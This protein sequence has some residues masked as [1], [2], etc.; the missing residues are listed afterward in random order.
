MKIADYIKSNLPYW[1]NSINNI[2]IKINI[3]GK[4]S[5][6]LGYVRYE[7]KMKKFNKEEALLNLV[8]YA[9]KHVPY[10]KK[11][12]GDLEILSISDFEKKIDF[13]DKD[14]VMN[15]WNDFI[16]DEINWDKVTT[17]TTGGTSG[18]PL[19]LVMPQNRY[20]HS[21]YFWHQQLKNFGWNYD[22][23]GVI[24]NHELPSNRVFLIN[25]IMKQFIF[26]GFNTSEE[27]FIKIWRVLNEKK[28]K[29]LHAYPSSAYA[30]LKTC[31]RYKL[32]TSFLR[33]VFL[34]SEVITDFQYQFI[35]H[36]LNIPVLGSYGHSEKLCMAGTTINNFNYVIEENYGYT[37][38]V[39]N[40]KLVS[41]KGIEGEIVGTTYNNYY[42]PLIRYKTGDYAEYTIISS[43]S[44]VF[45]HIEGR[46]RKALIYKDD[47]SFVSITAL[48]LHSDYYE[49]IS[50][51]QYIQ[52]KIGYLIVLIIKDNNYTFEDDQFITEYYANA[53][54]GKE[55]IE[56]RYV[57][58]L[59]FQSNGKF[60]PLIS[61]I[62]ET[63]LLNNQ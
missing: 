60:L 38:L 17:G 48:N 24:R 11:K 27:Y 26:D 13:I 55:Y 61:N 51:L 10:Y 57:S 59:I 47:G 39:K 40:N 9:I 16:S 4:Y 25:P 20:V 33:A 49:R 43:K 14:E 34:T 15:N 7:R 56:I 46:R 19:K 58:K 29:F 42:F 50:G 21:M 22:V 52:N 5:Y 62:S 18:K 35:R 36:T 12:Y 30:F 2:L 45:K 54:G 63:D 31:Y 32:D 41:Q 28:I 37:E 6:G 8:N 23:V 53:M 44:R 3:L 1:P